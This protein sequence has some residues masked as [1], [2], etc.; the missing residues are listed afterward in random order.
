MFARN[1][2]YGRLLLADE[3]PAPPLIGM[4]DASLPLEAGPGLIHVVGR[5]NG[6]PGNRG[7]GPLLRRRHA[8]YN[9]IVDGGVFTRPPTVGAT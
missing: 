6:S 3:R 8:P 2:R 9:V 7:Q 4:G 5:A 1:S